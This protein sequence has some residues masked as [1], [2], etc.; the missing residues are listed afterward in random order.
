MNFA[1]TQLEGQMVKRTLVWN[2][3]MVKRYFE[4]HLELVRWRAQQGL[5]LCPFHADSTPSLSV[6]AELAVFF[7]HACKAQGNIVTFEAER[8]GID[9]STAWHEL[10]HLMVIL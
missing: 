10:K 6:N 3:E 8:R 7:C 5:A 9:T 4:T 1:R 2:P